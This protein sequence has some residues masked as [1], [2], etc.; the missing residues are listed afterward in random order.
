MRLL[1]F[2]FLLFFEIATAQETVWFD[3]EWNETT[4][5][6]AEFYRPNPSKVK[7]GYWVIDYYKNGTIKRE[8]YA[9]HYKRKKAGFD[10]L[11]IEYFENG[12]PSIKSNYRDG[13]LSGICREYFK[14]GE[15]KKQYRH[16][17]GKRN[18]VWK[19]FY[20]SGKIKTKGKYKDGERVGIWKTYYKNTYESFFD[21]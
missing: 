2:I 14:T 15:L 7:K 12:K 13:Q 9:K 8:G 6:K 16:K 3:A 17:E 4:Q 10:G 11:V 18:G 1:T 21:Y 19:E 5:E 20:E